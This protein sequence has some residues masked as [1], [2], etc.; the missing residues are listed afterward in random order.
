MQSLTST[1]KVD[2]VKLLACYLFTY[3]RDCA[4]LKNQEKNSTVAGHKTKT[5]QH[6]LQKCSGELR[7]LAEL[8]IFLSYYYKQFISYNYSHC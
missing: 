7:E 1:Y 2:I 6:S 3:L 4:T 8:V 5:K